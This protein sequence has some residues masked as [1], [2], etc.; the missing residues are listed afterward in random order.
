MGYERSQKAET[1]RMKTLEFDPSTS[2][3]C[4]GHVFDLPGAPSSFRSPPQRSR[5]HFPRLIALEQSG[6]QREIPSRGL[7]YPRVNAVHCIHG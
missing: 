1:L 2:G 7:T 4:G 3:L 6:I 5:L